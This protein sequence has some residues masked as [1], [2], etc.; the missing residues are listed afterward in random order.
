MS[1]AEDQI[2]QDMVD[3][4]MTYFIEAHE[5][6]GHRLNV[7]SG[8]MYPVQSRVERYLVSEDDIRNLLFETSIKDLCYLAET[9]LMEKYPEENYDSMEWNKIV[10]IAAFGLAKKFLTEKQKWCLGSFIIFYSGR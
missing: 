9:V 2:E 10:D 8:R 6:E 3:T 5:A 7:N 1:Y 4:A